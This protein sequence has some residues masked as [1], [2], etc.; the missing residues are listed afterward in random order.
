M[1]EDFTEQLFKKSYTELTVEEKNVIAEWCTSEED[2]VHMASVIRLAS[3][4]RTENQFEPNSSTKDSLD[5]L[6]MQRHPKA[7]YSNLFG[8]IMSVINPPEQVFY[9]RPLM[10]FAAILSAILI[11]LP[12]LFDNEKEIQNPKDKELISTNK[13]IKPIKKKLK[14]NSKEEVVKSKWQKNNPLLQASADFPSE[15]IESSTSGMS[16]S[17]IGLAEFSDDEP[18]SAPMML[19]E[20]PAMRV[21][22]KSEVFNHSDGIYNGVPLKYSISIKDKPELIDLITVAF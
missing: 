9:R 7:I 3:A 15:Q 21:A 5:T 16:I 22:A 12:F 8:A 4:V 1:K 17:E 13:E 20:A 11:S 2:F 6:F 19:E 10:Q 18:V 14:E